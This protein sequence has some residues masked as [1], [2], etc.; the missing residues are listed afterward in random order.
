MAVLGLIA[1]WMFM[2]EG[3]GVEAKYFKELHP[4]YVEFQ[5]LRKKNGSPGELKAIAD[6]VAKVCPPIVKALEPRANSSRPVSQ[7]LFWVAKYRMNEMITKGA[8]KRTS[9][10]IQCERMLYEVAQQLKI[11]MDKP[12]P[13]EVIPLKTSTA[14]V[15]PAKGGKPVPILNDYGP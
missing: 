1:A 6:K 15:G 13:A 7:K 8:A 4:I 11:P 2:P 14:G 12:E 9:E 5:Q 3:F 10:E